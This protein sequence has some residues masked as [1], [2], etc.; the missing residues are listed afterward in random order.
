MR[1]R[2]PSDGK[3]TLQLCFNLQDSFQRLWIKPLC[4]TYRLSWLPK[5]ILEP[6]KPCAD[7]PTN[8]TVPATVPP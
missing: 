2:R 1:D 7:G 6:G 4:S 8:Q 5:G 3:Q